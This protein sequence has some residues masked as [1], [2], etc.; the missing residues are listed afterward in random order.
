ML[1]TGGLRGISWGENYAPLEPPKLPTASRTPSRAG[2]CSVQRPKQLQTDW[3]LTAAFVHHPLFQTP[4]QKLQSHRMQCHWHRH[5]TAGHPLISPGGNFGDFLQDNSKNSKRS[6][7]QKNPKVRKTPKKKKLQK[8]SKTQQKKIQNFPQKLSP[9]DP[10][11]PV[12]C[13]VPCICTPTSPLSKHRPGSGKWQKPGAPM[14]GQGRVY[15]RHTYHGPTGT[16]KAMGPKSAETRGRSVRNKGVRTRGGGVCGSDPTNAQNVFQGRRHRCPVL[17]AGLKTDRHPLVEDW[18]LD[19]HPFVR[20]TR[21]DCPAWRSEHGGGGLP[22]C[23]RL[24]LSLFC[25]S[26]TLHMESTPPARATLPP[27]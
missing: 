24:G 7:K 16:A 21:L 15:W 10:P 26:V 6:Q 20:V 19:R 4:A 12:C 2:P 17:C 25:T 18:D 22:L 8:D 23:A 27:V 5:C 3:P 1:S 13:L 9:P 11:H 14:V